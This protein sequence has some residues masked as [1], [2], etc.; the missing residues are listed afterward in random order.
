[1]SPCEQ[2]LAPCISACQAEA[3]PIYL[4]LPMLFECQ[5]APTSLA[6]AGAGAATSI[7]VFT[8]TPG[9]EPMSWPPNIQP[10][11]GVSMPYTQA[12]AWLNALYAVQVMLYGC[13]A[14][15]LLQR[16]ARADGCHCCSMAMSS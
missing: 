8:M 13:C 5:Q 10:L 16:C 15:L 9:S 1:M 14:C 12:S 4:P 6:A 3:G 11:L 7:G 2:Q